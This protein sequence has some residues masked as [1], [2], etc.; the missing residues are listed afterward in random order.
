[1]ANSTASRIVYNALHLAGFKEDG[2]AI[3]KPH[4]ELMQVKVNVA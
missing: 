2:E 4:C 1:M 3:P